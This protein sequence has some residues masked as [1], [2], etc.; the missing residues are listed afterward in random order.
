M[1][2]PEWPPQRLEADNGVQVLLGKL[3][4]FFLVDE[5]RLQFTAFQDLYNIWRQ[6]DGNVG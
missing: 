3:D 5:G 2:G 4:N 6:G 1:G